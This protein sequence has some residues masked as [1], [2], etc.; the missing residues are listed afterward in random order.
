MISSES[1]EDRLRELAEDLYRKILAQKDK[2]VLEVEGLKRF[3]EIVSQ[4]YS[5]VVF[6]N[7]RCPVCKRFLPIFE[8]YAATKSISRSDIKFVKINTTLKENALLSIIYEVFA[9]PTIIVFKD[10]SLVAR[11]EGYMDL[12]ELEK[13]V[14][15][16]LE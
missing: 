7:P 16:A 4:G 12:D 14:S 11:H 10:G 15:S 8:E 5:V 2:F 3:G 13:F 9:V 1:V 6:Y